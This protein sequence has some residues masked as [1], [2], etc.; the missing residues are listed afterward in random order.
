MIRQTALFL[1][2]ATQQLTQEELRIDLSRRHL[3]AQAEFCSP[4]HLPGTRMQCQ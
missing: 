1:R 2:F 4:G 3:L